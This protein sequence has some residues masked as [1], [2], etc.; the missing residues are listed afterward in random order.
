MKKFLTMKNFDK[1]TNII[2]F[3]TAAISFYHMQNK[4]LLS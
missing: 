3:L 4:P 1:T 2:L